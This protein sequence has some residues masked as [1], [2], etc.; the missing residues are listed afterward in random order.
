MITEKTKPAS[1]PWV[2]NNNKFF[3]VILFIIYLIRYQISRVFTMK[4]IEETLSISYT[5]KRGKGILRLVEF[6]DNGHYIVYVPSLNL[7]AYGNTFDEAF[8]MMSDV[9][10]EDFFENLLER[11]E[12]IVYDHLSNLGW[13]KSSTDSQGLS[14]SVHVDTEGILK[15]FNLS[16]DTK[17]RETLVEV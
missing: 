2:T 15:N 12:K 10:I 14:N 16:A 3:V 7:S 9:V 4:E 6:Q 1:Q 8:Q 5:H 11:P 13:H 17:I